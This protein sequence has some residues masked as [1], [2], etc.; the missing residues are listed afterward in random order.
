MHDPEKKR[1][2]NRK[3]R[4]EH[5]EQ[6][7]AS[8]RAYK[9]AHAE[10][11]AAYQRVYRA[12]NRD[13]LRSARLIYEETH[14]EELRAYKESH[15]R[16]SRASKLRNKYNVTLEWFDTQLAA[17]D[18]KCA[19]C[20]RVMTPGLDTCVDHN[21][22]T[23]TARSLLCRGCNMGIGHLGDDPERLAAASQYVYGHQALVAA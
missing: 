19:I 22:A 4:A 6:L 17:Q 18:G 3:Y 20:G 16:E 21:H 15:K 9:A 10:E 1:I 13:R 23:G 8:D 7:A 2:Y 11:Q 5:K 12:A 14:R